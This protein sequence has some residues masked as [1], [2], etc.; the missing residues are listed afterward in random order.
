[1]HTICRYCNT[2]KHSVGRDLRCWVIQ[3]QNWSGWKSTCSQIQ[4]CSLASRIQIHPTIGTTQMD[5]G[6]NE[7]GFDKN[8]DLAAREIPFVWHVPPGASTIDIKKTCSESPERARSTIN[9]GLHHIRAHV[10]RHWLDKEE[11]YR[12]LFA[13]R[14]RSGNTC[15]NIHARTLVFPGAR[16]CKNVVERKSQRTPRTMEQCS[17]ADDWHVQVSHFTSNVSSDSSI[18]AWPIEQRKKKLPLPKHIWEHKDVHQEWK[19]QATYCVSTIAFASGVIP[20]KLAPTQRRLEEEEIFLDRNMSQAPGDSMLETLIHK[21]SAQAE[22]A[23]RVEIGSCE[24]T[25]EPVVDLNSF[26]QRILRAKEFSKFKLSSCSWRSRE[27]WARDKN[28]SIRICRNSGYRSVRYRH[29]SQRNLTVRDSVF[30]KILNS[31]IMEQCFRLSLRP[32]DD[33]EHRRK[34]TVTSNA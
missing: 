10:Q 3:Q 21:A 23:R 24:N 30:P 6:R 18:T 25:N 17:I 29:D 33:R 5:E 16:V 34:W 26:T 27:D 12:I 28:R 4:P 7:H 11:Q 8:L 15:G 20:K 13:Q 19:W 2:G 9:R 1:M 14:Q 32:A 22:F 31:K